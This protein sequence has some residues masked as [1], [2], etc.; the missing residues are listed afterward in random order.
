MLAGK[1]GA[2]LGVANKR[3]LAWAVARAAAREGAELVVT[4]QNERF[5]RSVR[6][7]VAELPGD[8]MLVPC[9]VDDPEQIERFAEVVGREKGGLDFL[10]HS[11]AYADPEELRDAFHH[12]SREG[13]RRALETS[14][15]SFISL[16]NALG[17]RIADGGSLVTLSYIGAVRVIPNYN[18]M[19]VAKAA[20]EATVRYLAYDLGDRAIRVNAVSSGPIRTLSAAGIGDFSRI[21]DHVEEMSPLRRN[22]NADEV[23]DVV[24]FLLSDHARAITGS[25]LYADGGYHT[26]GL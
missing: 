5:E 4:C 13:F 8:P 21:L 15:H 6:P 17:P 10:V 18:L 23:A 25:V 19:G 16:A 26:M 2:V 1:K 9:D 22:V 20:L 11:I 12:T 14:V 7:L 24:A 3:S